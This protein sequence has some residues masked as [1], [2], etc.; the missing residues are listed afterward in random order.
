MQR[1][2]NEQIGTIRL[3]DQGFER[4]VLRVPLE[5]RPCEFHSGLPDLL[6][7]PV[8]DGP[9][10]TAVTDHVGEEKIQMHDEVLILLIVMR[11][12][13]LT[14]RA[15]ERVETSPAHTAASSPAIRSGSPVSM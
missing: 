14:V 12:Q 5:E 6:L 1:K 13:L 3:I 9:P 8:K 15:G 2:L 7:G 4:R 11:Q 10:L